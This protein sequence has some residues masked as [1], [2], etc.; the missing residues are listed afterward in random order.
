MANERTL[1]SYYR[2]GLAC[3]G[4]GAFIFKFYQTTTFVILS[5]LMVVIGIAIAIYGTF[6]YRTYKSKI[7]KH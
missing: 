5:V 2:S 6:R 3:L 7:L 1:M 4:I